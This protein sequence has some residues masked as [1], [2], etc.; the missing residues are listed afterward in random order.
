MGASDKTR[1]ESDEIIRELVIP[2]SEV[3]PGQGDPDDDRSPSD[4]ETRNV[5]VEP[6]PDD[7]DEEE[8]VRKPVVP[9]AK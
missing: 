6:L 7:G 1:P 5:P 3:N 9:D 2:D 8:T 4:E